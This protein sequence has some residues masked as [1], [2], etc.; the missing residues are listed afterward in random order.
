MTT[1]LEAVAQVSDA[2]QQTR[3]PLSIIVA[4]HNGSGKST[5]WRRDLSA[6]LQIPLINADRML[7]SILPEANADGFIPDWAAELRDGDPA[8][9]RVAQQGVASFVG[10]AMTAK[11]PFAMETVFSHELVRR[12]GTRETKIDLIRDMQNAGYFV[13]LFFVG[14]TNADLSVLR[15][16]TRVAQGGHGIPE[17]KLRE[18][19]PKTQRI[20][21]EASLVADATIMADNSRDERQAFT[22]SRVQL[23]DRL[24]FDLRN[25]PGGAPRVVARW[26]DIVA[27]DRQ[28][29]GKP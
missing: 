2:Q 11:T 17:A 1:L 26:M 25:A 12:D 6:V 10:H 15:V 5:M 19:F 21:G 28:A 13:L 9:L 20:I 7:L 8:W 22:V 29:R 14:L 18:R 27:P 23:K 24:I 4:G 16:Q 3:K